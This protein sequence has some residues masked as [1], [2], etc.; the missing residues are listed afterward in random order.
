MN[1]ARLHCRLS[2]D[3]CLTRH[4]LLGKIMGHESSCYRCRQYQAIKLFTDWNES[5]VKETTY[6]KP[7]RKNAFRGGRWRKERDIY[8]NSKISLKD[9]RYKR[10]HVCG[11]LRVKKDFTPNVK[12]KDGLSNV[13]CHCKAE[14]RQR[15]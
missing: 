5:P 15:G 6:H 7:S 11:R 3:S 1:C 12:S 2:V 9:V 8:E 4:D 14:R 10:C 13:C